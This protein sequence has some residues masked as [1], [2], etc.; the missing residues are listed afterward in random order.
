VIEKITDIISDT[1]E[2]HQ[3]GIVVEGWGWL[4]ADDDAMF[5]KTIDK[6][7]EL[8]CDA[9]DVSLAG[10][11]FMD[12]HGKEELVLYH[13]E[14]AESYYFEGKKRNLQMLKDYLEGKFNGQE[15]W[16]D[17]QLDNIWQAYQDDSKQYATR[18]WRSVMSAVKLDHDVNLFGIFHAQEDVAYVVDYN[19]VDTDNRLFVA[20][21][22][23]GKTVVISD[24]GDKLTV[25]IFD[26]DQSNLE[27]EAEVEYNNA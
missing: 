23:A 13:Y 12:R 24:E 20:V 19:H 22:H 26:L 25:H 15:L 2:I 10:I 7:I 1:R 6:H 8:L 14:T 9:F 27:A 5:S 3:M 17:K 18:E 4:Y 11:G 21:P 16:I